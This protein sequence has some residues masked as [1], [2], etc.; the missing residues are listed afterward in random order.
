MNNSKLAQFLRKHTESDPAWV[1][2]DECLYI[3]NK[4]NVFRVSNN[5]KLEGWIPE[6]QGQTHIMPSRYNSWSYGRQEQV[7]RKEMSE[8]Y[9]PLSVWNRLREMFTQSAQEQLSPSSRLIDHGK[10]YGMYRAFRRPGGE[11][12]WLPKELTDIFSAD[13]EELKDDF[14]FW[15][16]PETN[17]VHVFEK[18]YRRKYDRQHGIDM[19]A[20]C[21]VVRLNNDE[22]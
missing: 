13:L 4:A 8:R 14:S 9:N 20:F 12:V 19:V 10:A 11:Y 17:C 1:H 7:L 21:A 16:M 5:E 2:N 3:A 15:F 6:E 22:W 18:V